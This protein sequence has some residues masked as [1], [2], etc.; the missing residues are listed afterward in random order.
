M[1]FIFLSGRFYYYLKLLFIY[2]LLA[3]LGFCRYVWA[4]SSCCEWGVLFAAVRGLIA[5]ASLIAKNGL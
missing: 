3:A 4:F 1:A 5:V 2:L